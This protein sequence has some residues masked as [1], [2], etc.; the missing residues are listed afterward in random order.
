M[1][2]PINNN[3]TNHVPTHS[4]STDELTLGIRW[5]GVYFEGNRDILSGMLF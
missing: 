1:H 2:I 4:N 5:G 3:F